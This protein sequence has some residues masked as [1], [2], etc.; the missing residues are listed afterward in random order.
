M[1]RGNVILKS[2][3]RRAFSTLHSSALISVSP[4]LHSFDITHWWVA[5]VKFIIKSGAAAGGGSRSSRWYFSRCKGE[6][7]K[8]IS[9]RDEY[10]YYVTSYTPPLDR[11][12]PEHYGST[13][14][15]IPSHRAADYWL[16]GGWT[17]ECGRFYSMHIL[18]AVMPSIGAE[19]FH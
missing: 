5:C 10:A 11:L 16:T 8:G 12:P 1:R 2:V 3:A 17:V 13:N 6:G 7:W 9:G 19:V 14:R 18:V 4:W 15:G